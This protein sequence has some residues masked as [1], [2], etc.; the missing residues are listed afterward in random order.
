MNER[1]VVTGVGPLSLAVRSRLSHLSLITVGL[2]LAFIGIAEAQVPEGTKIVRS[3][4]GN[5]QGEVG[6]SIL[7]LPNGGFL[8]AG[9]E[10]DD[11]KGEWDA[12]TL[13]VGPDGRQMWRR[14]SDLAGHDYAWVVR[15]KE[16]NQFVVVGTRPT[17]GGDADGYMECLDG[18]GKTLWLRTFGGPGSE[19]LWAAP[20]VPIILRQKVNVNRRA[21]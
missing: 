9:Y 6:T 10:Y 14:A 3:T 16:E 18:D 4:V 15:E 1:P 19:V 12:L 2:C 17:A 20:S 21:I 13:G 5:E 8:V 7:E 11:W